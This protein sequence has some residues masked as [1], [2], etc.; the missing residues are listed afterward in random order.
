M[1]T[2]SPRRACARLVTGRSGAPLAENSTISS[3]ANDARAGL[4]KHPV[5]R[6]DT[7]DADHQPFEGGET[8]VENH[9][10]I[11]LHD[12]HRH[13]QGQ[14]VDEKRH[15]RDLAECRPQRPQKGTEP[16]ATRGAHTYSTP[17]WD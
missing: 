11:D 17:K 16:G 10:V 9:S 2:S 5:E 7:D 1:A 12:E 13:R 6:E 3:D 15:H 4:A 8:G 14:Q